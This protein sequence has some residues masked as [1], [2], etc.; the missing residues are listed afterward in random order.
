MH[1]V[2]ADHLRWRARCESIGT[3]RQTVEARNKVTA[4][5]LKAL[6]LKAGQA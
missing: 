2:V 3:T 5:I 6:G 4:C 1:K